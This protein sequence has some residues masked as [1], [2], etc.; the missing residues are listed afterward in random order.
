VQKAL[1]DAREH[2]AMLEDHL[3]GAKDSRNV[4]EERIEQQVATRKL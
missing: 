4:L 1:D 2:S 3:A